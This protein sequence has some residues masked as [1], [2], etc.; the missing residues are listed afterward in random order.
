MNSK[1]CRWIIKSATIL[2]VVF[3]SIAASF[4]VIKADYPYYRITGPGNTG[5][6]DGQFNP[7]LQKQ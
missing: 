4:S 3:L 1:S 5:R 2:F 7:D 6:I